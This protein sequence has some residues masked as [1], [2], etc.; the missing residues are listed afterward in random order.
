M[1]VL[2]L[3]EFGFPDKKFYFEGESE[4]KKDGSRLL[5]LLSESHKVVPVVRGNILSCVLLDDE[6]LLAFV[7]LEHNP[8]DQVEPVKYSKSDDRFADVEAVI[9][10]DIADVGEPRFGTGV[11]RLTGVTTEV[12]E[13]MELWNQAGKIELEI[14]MKHIERKQSQVYDRLRKELPDKKPVALDAIAKREA[15]TDPETLKMF[16]DEFGPHSIN[17]QRDEAIVAKLL[18][19]WD[20]L[21]R[22]RIALLNAGGKHIDRIQD[23]LPPDVRWICVRPVDSTEMDCTLS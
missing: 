9:Q 11:R 20:D 5:I 7:G 13:D 4:Q 12:V 18:K 15:E 16:R 22:D 21:G 2:D 1:Q 10:A 14:K 3:S 6:K 17:M 8:A 19:R 23:M